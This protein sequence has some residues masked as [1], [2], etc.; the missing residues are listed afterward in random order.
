[1]LLFVPRLWMLHRCVQDMSPAC[2]SFCR[3]FVL[4]KAV[5]AAIDTSWLTQEDKEEEPKTCFLRC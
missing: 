3:D 1:M 5:V 2:C 4:A